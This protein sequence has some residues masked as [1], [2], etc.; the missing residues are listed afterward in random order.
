MFARAC[1]TAIPLVLACPA[2]AEEVPSGDSSAILV[3]AARTQLPANALPMT[4]DIIDAATL[5]RQVAVSG[6]TVDAIS[7]LL[8]SFSPTREKLSGAGES[9]RGRS[10]L[11]AINGIP[12]STP[13]RD[14]SRDGYT[15]DPFFIDRVEVIYGSNALQGIGATG[16]VVNQVTVS[17][18]R[19]DGVTMRTLLQGTAADGFDG[20]ALG[21]KGGALVNYRAGA[22]DM[23]AGAT[24]ERRGVF[25]DGHGNGIGIDGTQGEI[26]DSDSWSVFGRIGYQLGPSTRLEVIANRFELKGNDHYVLVPGNRAAGI[27]ASSTRGQTPGDP[28]SNRAELLS[29][30]LTAGDLAGGTLIVDGF[31]SRT[32]DIFGGLV[33]SSFQDPTIDPTGSLFDQSANLSRKLGG[34]ISYERAVPGFEDLV[35]TAG[36]DA[37]FD[38]TKQYLVQTDREWVPETDFRSLAPFAQANL[39]LFD[40]VVRLAGGLRYENAKLSVGDYLTLAANGATNPA[41]VSTYKPIQVSGGSPSFSNVLWNGGAIVEPIN[42]LRAYASYAEGYT[43]ADVGRILRASSEDYSNVA[44]LVIACLVG[45]CLGFLPHN[46]H[47]AR[48]FM[49][50]SGSMVIGLVIAAA[51]IIVTGQINPA[52]VSQRQAIPAFLPIVLPLAVLILPLLDMGL[53]VVRRLLKG[54]SP[55]APDRMHLHHR[56]LQLGHSHRRAVFVLYLWTALVAVP[57]ALLAVWTWPAVLASFAVGVVVVLAITFGPLRGR[58]PR[59]VPAP[60]ANAPEP[61]PAGPAAEPAPATTAKE[62]TPT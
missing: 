14:G 55:F 60:A 9:L 54:K 56:M 20:S 30:S 26:Q 18:P 17:A 19:E 49:G 23:S 34:K 12:Q 6:S 50:D 29:A 59:P 15:I 38:R 62:E 13:V 27:P 33:T 21:G 46:M 43:I 36:F 44:S 25:L 32:R 1:L 5:E 42:G 22:F 37:L 2:Y 61:P 3:S 51:A 11:Y 35:L 40:G 45:A 47:P 10:P 4:V 57:A 53:A 28:P 16:G 39:K 52:I 48:I 7:A 24:F 31:F 58:A 41:D 8:P